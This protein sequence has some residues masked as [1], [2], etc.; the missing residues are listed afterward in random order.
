V[1]LFFY[2]K[3]EDMLAKVSDLIGSEDLKFRF[4]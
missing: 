1:S 2:P 4:I 3:G